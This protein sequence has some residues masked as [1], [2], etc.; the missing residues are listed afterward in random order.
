MATIFR[1]SFKLPSESIIRTGVPRTD[2]FFDL[3]K[4]REVKASF[5][6]QYPNIR[7][8]SAILY[9]PT[10]RDDK[11]ENYRLHLDIEKLSQELSNDYVLLI[12]LHP[13]VSYSLNEEYKD[14]V[15]DVSHWHDTNALLLNTDLLITDYSSIPFEYA[16]LEKPMIFFAYDLDDYRSSRGLIENYVEQMP[17][18]VVNSTEDIIACINENQFP[19]G[20]IAQFSKTWNEYSKGHSSDN[21]ALFITSLEDREKKRVYL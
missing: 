21:L 13:A 19:N 17:G 10:F 12:K 15:I 2:I 18:P 8:R 6:A 14:F 11:L 20:K 9:A 5:K 3:R 4:K 1:K 16:L 7:N